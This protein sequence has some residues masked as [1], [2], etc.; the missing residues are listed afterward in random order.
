MK[1]KFIMF[2]GRRTKLDETEEEHISIAIA[3]D[4]A[5]EIVKDVAEVKTVTLWY[6]CHMLGSHGV[7]KETTF[8]SQIKR[9][10]DE[11]LNK[12]ADE[13]LEAL[14]LEP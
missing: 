1:F 5:R 7:K 13:L 11:Y 12:Q 9:V 2:N 4:R 8:D 3:Q 14:R 6:D 10:S